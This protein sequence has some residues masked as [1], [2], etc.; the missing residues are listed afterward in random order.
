MNAEPRIT[1]AIAASLS[2]WLSR[3]WAYRSANGTPAWGSVLTIPS[4]GATSDP[5]HKARRIAGI[6]AGFVDVSRHHRTC[7]DHDVI[8]D[9]HRQ[10]AGVGADGDK[11][12]H[13]R[14]LPQIAAGTCRRPDP[15]RIV[16]EHGPMR[17]HAVRP[18]F[19]QLTD[20][21]MRLDTRARADDR[22]TLDLDE[23]AD[24]HIVL[25]TATIDVRRLHNGHVLPHLDVHDSRLSQA[26]IEIGRAHV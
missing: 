22:A 9:R 26:G 15:V 10:D 3:Y 7:A 11:R 12:T 5:A 1:A 20:E 17:H 21:G 6:D 16:Y 18:D 14:R 25:Q 13:A 19:H 4:S 24:E 8:A 23:R 2:G